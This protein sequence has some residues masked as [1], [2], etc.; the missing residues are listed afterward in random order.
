MAGINVVGAVLHI[1]ADD[2]QPAGGG[3]LRVELAHGACRRVA[4]IGKQGLAPCLPLGIELTEDGLGHIDLAPDNEARG[5]VFNAQRQRAHRAQI[6][7]HVLPYKAVTPGG[8]A[9]KYAVFIFQR[10]GQPVD[11]RL[12]RIAVGLNEQGIHALAEGVELIERENVRQALQRDLML[13]LL[14]LAQGLPAHPLGGGIGR[15]KLGVLLL[16]LLEPLHEHVKFIVG[17]DR[18]ILHIVK[19]AVVFQLPAEPVDLLLYIHDDSSFYSIL[20]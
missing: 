13:H 17:N 1:E 10:H 11:L 3:H 12:H 14:K 5:G 15:D 18:R 8:A 19:T 16:Q 6:L 7:R 4:G 2:V 20:R 9:D